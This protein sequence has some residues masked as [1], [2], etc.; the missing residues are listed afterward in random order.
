MACQELS[1]EALIFQKILKLLLD[2]YKSVV[3]S[4]RVLL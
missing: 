3:D 4:P 1:S 2:S